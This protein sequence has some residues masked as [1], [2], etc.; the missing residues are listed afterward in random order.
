[1]PPKVSPAAGR[2]IEPER[3]ELAGLLLRFRPM[4]DA[5][6]ERGALT[7]GALRRWLPLALA[8]GAVTLAC[9]LP[10]DPEGTLC[11]ADRRLLTEPPR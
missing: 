10:R 4:A 6:A 2:R 1:M 5:A 8:A 3:A 9:A 11:A 7:R